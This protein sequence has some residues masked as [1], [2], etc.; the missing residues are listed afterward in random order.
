MNVAQTSIQELSLQNQKMLENT[1]VAMQG[2]LNQV[3]HDNAQAIKDAFLQAQLP[4]QQI[5]TTSQT[6]IERANQR[7]VELFTTRIVP[8]ITAF[9]DAVTSLQEQAR[10][11]QRGADKL[12]KIT[13]Q[14]TAVTGSLATN[15]DAY[16]S[17]SRSLD[18]HIYDFNAHMSELNKIQIEV[19]AQSRTLAT[20]IGAIE[21]SFTGTTRSMEA[22]TKSVAVASESMI[23]QIDK[24]TI[25]VQ[26]AAKTVKLVEQYMGGTSNHL[27]QTNDQLLRITQEL[28]DVA[29]ALAGIKIIDGG[30][31]GWLLARG[32]NR[33]SSS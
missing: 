28:R 22:A 9:N 7:E 31:L 30:V 20:K 14:L 32:Q 13:E 29:D 11:Y 33:I 10:S 26:D 19:A 18:A 27:I 25:L 5:V 15:A 16:T 2:V 21:A 8:L 3:A 4:L 17:L 6:A 12:L 24:M 1:T 23:K